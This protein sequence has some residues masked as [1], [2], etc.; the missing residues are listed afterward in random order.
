M[1]LGSRFSLDKVAGV[2]RKWLEDDFQAPKK[3]RHTARRMYTRLVEENGFSGS[4]STVRRWVRGCK[5]DLGYGREEAVIPLAPE[6]AREAEV[7]WGR[8]WL[9]MKSALIRGTPYIIIDRVKR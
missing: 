9:E 1:G 5:A 4:E 6:A 8:A 7:D 3:Q 2:L